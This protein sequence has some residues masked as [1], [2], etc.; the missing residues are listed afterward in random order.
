MNEPTIVEIVEES[1]RRRR[2][3]PNLD[4]TALLVIDMQEHFREMA[5]QILSPLKAII[6]RFRSKG[7]P[8]FFTQHM[9]RNREDGMLFRWW[10]SL[11]MEG[12]QDAHLLPEI[13]PK[14]GETVIVKRRYSAFYRT[15]L[16][17]HL[18]S[19]GIRDLII[20]GVMTNLC[21]ETTA[22]DAFMR[23]YRVFF[24][25]DGTATAHLE[26]QLATLKNLAF[27]FAYLLTCEEMVCILGEE[28]CETGFSTCL[29]HDVL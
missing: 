28:A 4:H 2:T 15:E 8:V 13:A 20:S 1:K 29:N 7:L 19:L 25:V 14:P 9:H 3:I 5:R 21:C 16:D 26:L 12:S 6:A 23:D 22:R 18:L 11:I 27:G 24:L 17:K 10:G